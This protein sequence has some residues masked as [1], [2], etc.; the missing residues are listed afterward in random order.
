MTPLMI[1]RI[2]FKSGTPIYLHTIEQ[3]RYAAASG[4]LKPG[5]PLP[6]LRPLA[7]ELRANR[8]T[9]AT[10]YTELQNI[11]TIDTRHGKGS[12]VSDNHSPLTQKATEEL[13]AAEID[14]AIVTAHH[15]QIPHDSFL[16]LVQKQ[17][18]FFENRKSE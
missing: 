8:N 4:E 13:L 14:K 1:I 17:L 2:D 11:A 15:L 7:E 12:V 9:I 18:A 16:K 3:I 5:A 6:A 10:A